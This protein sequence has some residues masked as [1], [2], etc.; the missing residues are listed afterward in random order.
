MTW[1]KIKK[2][3]D[4]KLN[5]QNDF[6]SSNSEKSV[7]LSVTS[8][9]IYLDF[10]RSLILV[11]A[12]LLHYKKFKISTQGRQLKQNR[13]LKIQS[14]SKVMQCIGYKI[15]NHLLVFKIMLW[16]MIGVG[17]LVN[18]HSLRINH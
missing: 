15:A 8:I 2:G 17:N 6:H 13:C 1:N 16:F 10:S 9:E 7:F 11:K 18:R 3:V 5:G 14:V 12:L 4:P